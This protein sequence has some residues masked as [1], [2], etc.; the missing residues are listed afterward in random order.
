MR[1][2]T[3]WCQPLS[4]FSMCLST[5]REAHNRLLVRAAPTREAVARDS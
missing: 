3:T 2:L 1:Y 5:V 4:A